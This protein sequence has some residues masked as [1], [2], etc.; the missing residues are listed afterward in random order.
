MDIDHLRRDLID[1]CLGAYFGGGFGAA[2]VESSDIAQASPEKLIEI[3][4]QIGINVWDY[5]E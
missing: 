3:A 2:L 5:E 4:Q 1:E